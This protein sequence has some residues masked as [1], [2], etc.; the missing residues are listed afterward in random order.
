M[1][2]NQIS[3]AIL[4]FT[5][6]LN[7]LCCQGQ[8]ISNNPYHL[9]IISNISEY[10]NLIA[11]NPDKI[12]VDIDLY[13]P[14]IVLDIRYATDN[15]F[16]NQK[17]YESAKAF[18]RKPVAD[19]L[20]KVQNE[21]QMNGIGLK[22]FDAYRP[23]SATVKLFEICPDTTYAASPSKGSK[24]NTGCAVDVSL[25]YLKTGKELDMPTQYDDFTK[26]AS[27]SYDK[28]PPQVKNNRKLLR[29]TM[30]KYGF[31]AYH[32]EWWHYTFI[33]TREF[34]LMD[35]PFNELPVD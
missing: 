13:I 5:L 28:L 11:E 4:G 27:H 18:L 14:S 20:L 8:S 33:K 6:L 15:N 25:I 17:I 16:T 19:S 31:I 1:I 32:A 34:E 9:N 10:K 30:E 2:I 24:H 29:E 3:K 35:I 22:I 12:L 21:L 23:Y 7:F 26:R